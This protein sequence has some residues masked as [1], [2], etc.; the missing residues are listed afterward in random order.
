MKFLTAF[1]SAALILLAPEA[2]SRDTKHELSIQDAMQSATFK[3]RLDPNIRFY[4]GNQKHPKVVRS[5][6]NYSTNKKTNA[7]NKS[8][9]E[10]C[11][12][13]LLSALLTLQD[14][15]KQEGANAVIN[16]ASYYKKNTFSSASLYECHA[17]A[18]LSGVALKGDVVKLAK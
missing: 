7:F 5:F 10:A 15:A 13:V 12:W 8:D 6:G 11:Q 2:Y 16:I 18:I 4:F 1:I 9:E 14:R 3:E 17:G